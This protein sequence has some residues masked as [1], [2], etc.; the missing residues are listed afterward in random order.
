MHKTSKIVESL[1]K[2][3]YSQM[4]LQDCEKINVSL[5]T[6]YPCRYALLPLKR[7]LALLHG[8]VLKYTF[9]FPISKKFTNWFCLSF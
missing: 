9:G 8:Q 5:Q 7:R 6:F 4:G 1:E 2:M 3:F